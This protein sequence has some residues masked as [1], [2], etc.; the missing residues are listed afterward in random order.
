[1]TAFEFHGRKKTTLAWPGRRGLRKD[2]QG[3]LYHIFRQKPTRDALSWLTATK[4]STPS[5][6]RFLHA[7]P[8]TTG[9]PKRPAGPSW[10]MSPMRSKRCGLAMACREAVADEYRDRDYER[11]RQRHGRLFTSAAFSGPGQ[12]RVVHRDDQGVRLPFAE[13]TGTRPTGSRL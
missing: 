12:V 1:G 5:M 11:Q 7:L 6:M 9:Y 4:S 2:W 13:R 3:C 8:P 10:I